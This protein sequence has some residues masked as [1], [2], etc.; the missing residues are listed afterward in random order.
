[1]TTSRNFCIRCRNCTYLYVSFG[2][3]WSS[4]KDLVYIQSERQPTWS[5]VAKK[6]VIGTRP[7]ALCG[8]AAARKDHQS[9]QPLRSLWVRL[10]VRSLDECSEELTKIDDTVYYVYVKIT[11]GYCATSSCL[12]L[13]HSWHSSRFPAGTR[14]PVL[15]FRYTCSLRRIKRCFFICVPIPRF[16]KYYSVSTSRILSSLWWWWWT[17]ASEPASQWTSVAWPS[18]KALLHPH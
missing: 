14:A 2:M 10:R 7:D 17:V 18:R 1:M 9:S 5:S 12:M 3:S 8:P 15:Y 4:R 6:C 13:S 11:R 16:L